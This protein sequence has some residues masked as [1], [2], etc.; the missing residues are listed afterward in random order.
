MPIGR[1]SQKHVA[2]G[3]HCRNIPIDC[4]YDFFG[5]FL[6]GPATNTPKEYLQKI[7]N[8]TSH[9]PIVTEITYPIQNSVCNGKS[10]LKFDPEIYCHKNYGLEREKILKMNYQT[11][12]GLW[13][14]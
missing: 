13:F 8:H 11:V 3:L 7:T 14:D 1:G 5:I 12:E 4:W 2:R 10:F 6:R 9:A